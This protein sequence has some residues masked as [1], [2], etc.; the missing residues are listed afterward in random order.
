M[1]QNVLF[2]TLR[3]NAKIDAAQ[4]SPTKSAGPLKK[5]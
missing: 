2:H 5:F 1:K 4:K 3:F